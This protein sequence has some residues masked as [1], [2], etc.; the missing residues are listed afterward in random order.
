MN[1]KYRICFVVAA[2]AISLAGCGSASDRAKEACA[3]Y[4]TALND[5]TDPKGGFIDEAKAVENY[6]KAS[7]IFREL[8]V[9][10][11]MFT[12]FYD[13]TDGLSDDGLHIGYDDWSD[14]DNFCDRPDR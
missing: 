2:L 1:A 12:P 14:L 8:S 4:I 6:K 10:N 5:Y 9:N 3:Y 13:V 7:E 11:E